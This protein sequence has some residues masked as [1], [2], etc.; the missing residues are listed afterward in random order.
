VIPLPLKAKLKAVDSTVNELELEFPADNLLLH[1]NIAPITPPSGVQPSVLNILGETPVEQV[2]ELRV[3]KGE[4]Q[5]FD[6]GRVIDVI[7]IID[8]KYVLRPL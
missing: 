6:L 1:S 2:V 4:N 7:L 8:H 5:T 3:A